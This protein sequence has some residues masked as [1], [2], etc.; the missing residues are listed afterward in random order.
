MT[1]K[2]FGLGHQSVIRVQ[3]VALCAP[4]VSEPH[5][6]GQIRIFAEIFFYSPPTWFPSEV[7]HGGQDHPDTGRAGFRCNCAPGSFR[8]LRVPRGGK[9]DGCRKDGSCVKT[10][11]A[12]LDKKRRDA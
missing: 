7:K 8:N 10:M 2:V 12:F 4:H 9:V 6:A 1:C 5:L 3:T 11:K